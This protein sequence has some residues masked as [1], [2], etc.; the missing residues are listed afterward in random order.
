V[1]PVF[2]ATPNFGAAAP[3]VPDCG[4]RRAGQEGAD[5]CLRP[6]QRA[7]VFPVFGCSGD[8][9]PRWPQVI[10]GGPVVRGSPRTNMTEQNPPPKQV[11][12]SIR[13]KPKH[14]ALT[15]AEPGNT[16]TKVDVRS[17]CPGWA[18]ADVQNRL[19]EEALVDP[20]GG[21]DSY[22]RPR[23]LWNAVGGFVFLGVSS[24]EPVPAYNCYPSEPLTELVD[25][26]RLRAERTVEALLWIGKVN[27]PP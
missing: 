11:P 15:K 4:T 7:N 27:G 12:P 2:F 16:R 19:M 8:R 6:G 14:H 13:C 17:R 23:K 9:V 18:V 20:L 24:N 10:G 26:L 3:P 22:G 25:T 21:S 5:T 1:P